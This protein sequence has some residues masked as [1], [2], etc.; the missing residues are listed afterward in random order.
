MAYTRQQQE[1]IIRKLQQQEQMERYRNNQKR[2]TPN[3]A[4]NDF[5]TAKNLISNSGRGLQNFGNLM[6]KSSN[7][8]INTLGSKVGNAG[9]K[10]V[11]FSQTPNTLKAGISNM[12]GSSAPSLAGTTGAGGSAIAN[13][14]SSMAPVASSALPSTIGATGGIGAGVSGLGAGSAAGTGALGSSALGSSLLGATG[15]GTA[16]GMGAAGAT[17]AIGGSTAAATGAGSAGLAAG[18]GGAMAAGSMAI[19]IVGWGVAA[20]L[21]AK[22]IKDKFDEAQQKVNRKAMEADAKAMQQSA[23]QANKNRQE[24]QQRMQQQSAL[25]A[26]A[27][28]QPMGETTGQSQVQSSNDMANE[29][30]NRIGQGQQPT[31]VFESMKTQLPVGQEIGY[32]AEK[33]ISD[34]AND[35]G[36]DYDLRDKYSNG[37]LLSIN[38]HLE[39]TYKLPIHPTFSTDSAKYYD[40]QDYA[41]NPETHEYLPNTKDEIMEAIRGGQPT[42]GAAPVTDEQEQLPLIQID[43]N[44]QVQPEDTKRSILEKLSSGL[45]DFKA[46]YDDNSLHGFSEGDMYNNVMNTQPTPQ[47][48]NGVLTGGAA[49]A[50]KSIM[51]R[52]G[53][54]AGTGRRLMANPWVQAGIAGVISK[55]DGGDIGDIA[56]AAYQYGTAKQKADSYYK[57]VN[58]DAKVM[59]V[60]NTLDAND[61]KAK[62]YNDFNKGRTM[63]S[64]RD[65]I[66]LNNPTWSDEQVE[67]YLSNSGIDGDEMLSLKGYDAVNKVQSKNRDLDIKQQKADNQ[68]TYWNNKI[69][70]DKAKVGVQQQ[71]A[72]TNAGRL[73]ETKRSN[74]VKEKQNQQSIDNKKAYYGNKANQQNSKDLEKELK[75]RGFTKVN[76]KWVKK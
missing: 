37:G 10:L 7:P 43:P 16:T 50:Q 14:I 41:V 71:N 63:I 72:N 5:K 46:G 67:T 59:P 70:V 32:Q 15:G 51:S 17:G 11:N 52:I 55:A 75:A 65:F 34:F 56:K 35:S 20:A 1:E 9:T 27:M 66:K 53:E 58:P 45:K 57:M 8:T 54:A 3:M 64:R 69:G 18:A 62:A 23:G 44:G 31:S 12:F 22:A 39:D 29:L 38:P 73:S 24:A 48:Q 60:F 49:K 76:G 36:Y 26:A 28:A 42:G 47:V 40:G 61:Y 2:Y 4:V 6:S 21:A 19:P 74:A 13:G 30:M 25:D 68:N 33:G